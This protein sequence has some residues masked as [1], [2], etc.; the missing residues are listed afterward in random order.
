[1]T[2]A[3]QDGDVFHGNP[4]ESEIY[5]T[6]EQAEQI[7]M[8]NAIGMFRGTQSELAHAV[9]L[10]GRATRIGDGTAPDG[11]PAYAAWHQVTEAV[12][13]DIICRFRDCGHRG[14][15]G[16]PCRMECNGVNCHCP[17]CQMLAGETVFGCSYGTAPKQQLTNMEPN[18]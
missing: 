17:C 10:I 2:P 6:D 5:M 9:L 7:V 14:V 1:M 13:Y 12:T 15:N 3:Q 8:A 4:H 16:I 18:R 11:F